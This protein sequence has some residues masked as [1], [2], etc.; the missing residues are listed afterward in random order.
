MT[1]DVS[2]TTTHQT[3][4]VSAYTQPHASPNKEEF[5]PAKES[6][7]VDPELYAR[8][9]RNTT[10]TF[11]KRIHGNAMSDAG[12]FDGDMVIVDRSIQPVNGRIIIAVLNEA[13]LIRRLV[14]HSVKIQL[15]PETS[16][17]SAIDLDPTCANFSV[18][19]VVTHVIHAL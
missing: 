17:L 8:L 16:G 4:P 13:T 19:G 7:G 12:I 1:P 2:F 15:V 5:L 9:T 10:T 11:L 18:W 6:Q 14:L 3:A